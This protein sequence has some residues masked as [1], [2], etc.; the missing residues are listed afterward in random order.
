MIMFQA[1]SQWWKLRQLIQAWKEYR[2]LL[3]RW[4]GSKDVP[5]EAEQHFLSLKARIASLLPLL[6]TQVP[7]GMVPE[8]SKHMELMTDLLNR[9]RTLHFEN[10]PGPKWRELFEQSWHMH[11]IFLNKLKGVKPGTARRPSAMRPAGVP[12]GLPRVHRVRGPLPGVGLLRFVVKLGLFALVVYLLGRAF[13]LRWEEG[14]HLTVQAPASVSA[15]G[16]NV[17][18]GAQTVWQSVAQFFHPVVS[19][20]GSTATI[21]L[22]AIAL[23]GLG[24]FIF[25]R[26]R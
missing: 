1:I 21:G 4:E 18:G 6:V 23:L 15:A 20:Y 25:I 8:A 19:A 3:L 10:P 17:A 16:H 5:A 26:G 12:T 14:Q 9:H 24:Y 13:G 7:A 22:V 2:D 11:F